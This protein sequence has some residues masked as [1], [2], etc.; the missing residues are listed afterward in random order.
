[1]RVSI[2]NAKAQATPGVRKGLGE[3]AGGANEVGCRI[4]RNFLKN[5]RARLNAAPTGMADYF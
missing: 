1:M 4:L 3:E 2:S 5:F